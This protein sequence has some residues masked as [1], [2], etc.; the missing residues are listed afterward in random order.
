MKDKALSGKA[1]L[2]E[3]LKLSDQTYIAKHPRAENEIQY[4]AGYLKKISQLTKR[5]KNPLHQYVKTTA[6]SLAGFAAAMLIIFCC[7]VMVDAMKG[8]IVGFFDIISSAISEKPI[9]Q[10]PG[11]QGTQSTDAVVEPQGTGSSVVSHEHEFTVLY[12]TDMQKH[13]Y[14]CS[15]SGCMEVLAEFH[16]YI[17][18]PGSYHLACE[19][20]G[21]IPK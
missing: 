7:F 3:A 8:T 12:K 2:K 6:Q 5:L 18:K 1:R 17:H 19:V 13:Y 10:N 11:H 4:S 16:K 14:I 9:T 20:C 21:R 15:K